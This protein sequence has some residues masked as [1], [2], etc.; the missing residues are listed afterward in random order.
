[1]Q[2]QDFGYIP[3][4]NER[5]AVNIVR[6][7]IVRY[8]RNSLLEGKVPEVNSDLEREIY[9]Q[10][11]EYIRYMEDCKRN[12]LDR[13]LVIDDDAATNEGFYVSGT[14]VLD[15]IL[16]FDFP[17]IEL[18]PRGVNERFSV[19]GKMYDLTEEAIA[20]K[21][22]ER[23]YLT[24]LL[25]GELKLNLEEGSLDGQI[26]LDRLRA[27]VYGALNRETQVYSISSVHNFK[28]QSGFL[29][30]PHQVVDG[31]ESPRRYFGNS[32]FDCVRGKNN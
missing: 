29:G 28:G 10:A 18:L 32:V 27:G 26:V 13:I 6:N 31:I 12:C 5:V 21:L 8:M 24:I 9:A 20:K 1:M 11:Q 30:K 23:K 25:D 15:S 3:A 17:H 7:K 19:E 14:Y 22:L 4:Y 16:P 2:T